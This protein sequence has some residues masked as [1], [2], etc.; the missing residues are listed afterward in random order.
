MVRENGIDFVVLE[1]G[2][3]TTIPLG[4]LFFRILAALAEFDR[5]MIVEGPSKAS[6]SPRPAAG[7]ADGRPSSPGQSSTRRSACST[8]AS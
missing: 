8:T 4:R 5:E 6:P 7:P 1:Q 2:I 3:D